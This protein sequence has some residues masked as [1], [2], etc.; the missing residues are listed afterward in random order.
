MFLLDSDILSLFHQGHT[1]VQ[2]RLRDCPSAEIGTTIISQAEIMKAR[3]DFLLKAADGEQ[4]LIAQHWLEESTALLS[5]WPVFKFDTDASVEFKALKRVRGLRKVG[6]AD[7]LIASI[8]LA[9]D[10]TVVTRNIKHFSAVPRLKC[11]NWA[12]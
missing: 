2:Q 1:G 12:D 7:L 11:E 3:F 10:A 5:Q 6:H 4:V 8:A 9:H